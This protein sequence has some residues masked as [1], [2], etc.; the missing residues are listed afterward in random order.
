MAASATTVFE[1]AMR[2][3]E[4]PNICAKEADDREGTGAKHKAIHEQHGMDFLIQLKRKNMGYALKN[5]IGR[6][7]EKKNF[8]SEDLVY[9][10]VIL[11]DLIL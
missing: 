11:K 3:G 6:K 2:S 9:S 10:E 1:S 7:S 8:Y 5:I 4:Q